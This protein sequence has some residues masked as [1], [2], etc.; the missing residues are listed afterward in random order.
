MEGF[1]YVKD[2]PAELIS[3]ARSVYI[4]DGQRGGDGENGCGAGKWEQLKP[5]HGTGFTS[6]GRQNKLSDRFGPEMSF[7]WR[8]QQLYPGERIALIKYARNGSGLDSLATGSFGCWEPGYKAK[9][10]QW[11]FFIETVEGALSVEDI[12][13]DGNPDRLIPGGIVWMQG[14]ADGSFSEAIAYEYYDN[15]NRLMTKMRDVFGNFDL[16]VVIGKI[17]DSGNSETGIVFKYGDIVRAMQEKF[18]EHD[19]NAAVVRSTSRYSY[20]DPW[21]YD[22]A[23]YIDLGRQFAEQM[24]KLLNRKP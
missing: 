6:D 13:G 11:D 3:T 5:G 18:V 22:S 24:S 15:L 1:G 23:G 2:L 14:E 19:R 10:N 21:H 4:F 12:D 16:P 17:S 9:Q 8:M 7:A 20:S